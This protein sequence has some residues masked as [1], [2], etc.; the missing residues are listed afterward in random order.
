[1]IG[2]VIVFPDGVDL[3]CSCGNRPDLDGFYPCD[4]TGRHV[5]PV[6]GGSWAGL[7][8]CDVCGALFRFGVTA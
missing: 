4:D 7:Y 2:G 6:A 1:M 3:V 8:V 5:E